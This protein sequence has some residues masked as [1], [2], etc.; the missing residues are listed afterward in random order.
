MINM[1]T[2]GLL[3]LKVLTDYV[4]QRAAFLL[5]IT[6]NSLAAKF[7]RSTLTNSYIWSYALSTLAEKTVMLL[8]YA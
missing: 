1:Q 5:H 4:L 3:W 6:F 8:H 2:N 7:F